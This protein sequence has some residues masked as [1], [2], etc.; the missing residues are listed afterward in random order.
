M[1]RQFEIA[2]SFTE[3]KRDH[4]FIYRGYQCGNNKL[5]GFRGWWRKRARP[6]GGSQ[7]GEDPTTLA[8]A[9]ENT[10]G[11]CTQSFVVL[12][13]MVKTSP[14]LQCA[15]LHCIS[16]HH[17][18]EVVETARTPYL[19]LQ[20]KSVQPTLRA[21]NRPNEASEQRPRVHHVRHA[22]LHGAWSRQRA[23]ATPSR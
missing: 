7:G 17:S 18:L 21:E 11:V 2:H 8:G 22:R 1:Q 23:P 15:F 20:K 14:V 3:N 6:L 5:S 16:T 4:S 9:P 13:P 12:S 10:T 19:N